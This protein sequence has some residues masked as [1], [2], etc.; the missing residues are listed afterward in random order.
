MVPG[1]GEAVRAR[2]DAMG[3]SLNQLAEKAETHF[4]TVSKVERNQRAVSLRLAA[5]LASALGVTVDVLLLDAARLTAASPP[6]SPP[7]PEPA[8]EKSAPKKGK[9]KK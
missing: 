8:I 4:T 5:A 1:F 3:W 7:A 9:G 2:R 6:A